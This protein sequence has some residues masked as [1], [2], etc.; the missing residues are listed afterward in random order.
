MDDEGSEPENERNAE[1]KEQCVEDPK[2]EEEVYHV[3]ITRMEA[4]E[5]AFWRSC[6]TGL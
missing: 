4:W 2:L 1:G 3:Q 6:Y 5:F